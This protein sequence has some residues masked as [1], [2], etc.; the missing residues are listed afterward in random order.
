MPDSQRNRR[1]TRSVHALAL[2]L[3]SLRLAGAG[4]VQIVDPSQQWCR[5]MRLQQ[6]SVCALVIVLISLH[7]MFSCDLLQRLFIRW[8]CQVFNPWPTNL[9]AQHQ[10]WIFHANKLL[11]PGVRLCIIGCHSSETHVKARAIIGTSRSEFVSLCHGSAA[12]CAVLRC[13]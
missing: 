12:R 8:F 13:W 9:E 2:E 5:D 11:L 10:W 3:S 6:L 7:P 4:K 1:L